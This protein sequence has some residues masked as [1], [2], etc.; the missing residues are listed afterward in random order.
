MYFIIPLVIILFVIVYFAFFKENKYKKTFQ[1]VVL[2]FLIYWL[3]GFVFMM[4]AEVRAGKEYG[5]STSVVL[6][7]PWAYVRSGFMAPFW[8][9][10]LYLD[11]KLAK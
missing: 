9:Y 10:F 2:G 5:Q 3:I 1:Y 8:P 7:S 6:T 4:N 11:Q